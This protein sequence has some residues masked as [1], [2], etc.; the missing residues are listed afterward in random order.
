[1]NTF[2]SVKYAF[3]IR[4]VDNKVKKQ[5]ICIELF[6]VWHANHVL[7]K[8]NTIQPKPSSK[9]QPPWNGF[10]HITVQLGFPQNLCKVQ[11]SVFSLLRMWT[12]LNEYFTNLHWTFP[13]HP[14]ATVITIRQ[15]YRFKYSYKYGWKCRSNTDIPDICH[16]FTLTYFEAWKFYTQKCVNLRQKLPRD[17][18]A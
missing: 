14:I 12:L 1:M 7:A 17:K 3:K 13:L 16:F 18:I 5:N 6:Y 11:P 15:K 10:F 8:S 4:N 9:Q 2:I